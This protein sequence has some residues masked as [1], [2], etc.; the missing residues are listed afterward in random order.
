MSIEITRQCYIDCPPEAVFAVLCDF[1]AYAQWNPWIVAAQGA[2]TSGA[3]VAVKAKLAKRVGQYQH[4]ILRIEAPYR[5]HWCDVGWFTHFAYGERKRELVAQGAGTNYTV[6]L[7]VSGCLSGLVNL[8][9]G[10]ALEKGMTEE[11]QALKQWVE[12]SCE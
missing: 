10:Q 3:K 12:K 6:T 5:L 8:L 4:R 9:Y 1:T 2:C 11:T 7:T